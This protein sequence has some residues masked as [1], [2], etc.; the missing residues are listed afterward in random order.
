MTTNTLRAKALQHADWLEKAGVKG[1]APVAAELRRLHGREVNLSAEVE[2]LKEERD[3]LRASFDELAAAVGWT[4]AQ[5][6]QTGDSPIDAAKSL[7]AQVSA[8]QA[9]AERYRWLREQDD[10][11]D[12][13]C[14]Y[15]KVGPWGECGHCE[16]YGELLDTSVDA[17]RTTKE[18]T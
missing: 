2:R 13:F 9:D 16:I 18:N 10:Q 7:R 11:S 15:G 1:G 4:Q 14:M 5:C 8:L 17:A 12:V 3:T 6:E